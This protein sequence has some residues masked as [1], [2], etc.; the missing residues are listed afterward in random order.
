MLQRA[1]NALGPPVVIEHVLSLVRAR[2]RSP[3]TGRTGNVRWR[4]RHGDSTLTCW[5]GV[6]PDR[7]F[8]AALGEPPRTRITVD[9]TLAA[10]IRYLG[11]R[12][13]LPR[14]FVTGKVR[15]R[16]DLTFIPAVRSW[17]PDE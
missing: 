11:N 16:G 1:I 17:F 14:A 2:F 13:D 15:V 5:F 12:L 3:A 9:T 6:Q 8:A 10:F 7:S 4:L